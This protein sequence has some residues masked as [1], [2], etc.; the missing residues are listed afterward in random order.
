[1]P[2][3]FHSSSAP[4]TEQTQQALQ[5]SK[6]VSTAKLVRQAVKLDR[7]ASEIARDF[8]MEYTLKTEERRQCIRQVRIARMAQRSLSHR[9]RRQWKWTEDGRKKEFLR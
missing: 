9:I 8:A 1:M 4:T 3:T 2:A 7:T 6:S 5:K